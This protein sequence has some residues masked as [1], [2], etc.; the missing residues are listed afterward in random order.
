MNTPTLPER[1]P[2]ALIMAAAAAVSATITLLAAFG[3]TLTD[4]QRDAILTTGVAWAVLLVVLIPLVR[5]S[6]TPRAAVVE[7]VTPA[8]VV[9]AGDAS[10]LPTGTP[11][12]E[13]GTLDPDAA[14]PLTE[15]RHAFPDA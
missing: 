12:R 2:V 5:S 10:E 11:V 1:E 8:G 7:R 14:T 15:A 4:A 13:I 6:V 3:L 9:V